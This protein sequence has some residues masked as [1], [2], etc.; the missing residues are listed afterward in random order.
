MNKNLV[1]IFTFRLCLVHHL[2]YLIPILLIV[3]YRFALLQYR[4]RIMYCPLSIH[5]STTL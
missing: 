5:N 4:L 3:T 1:L 2:A